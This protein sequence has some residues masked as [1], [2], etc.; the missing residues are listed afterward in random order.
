VRPR[1]RRLDARDSAF[2]RP[3]EREVAE[4][5]VAVGN[6]LIEQVIAHMAFARSEMTR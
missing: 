6:E 1:A 2:R 5:V 4:D 3:S